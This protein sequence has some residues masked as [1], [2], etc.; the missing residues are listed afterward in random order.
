MIE[1][2]AYDW[3]QGLRGACY[4]GHRE[5]VDLMIEKGA[6]DWN[7]GLCCA[8]RYGHREIVDLM[9]EKGATYLNYL[10]CANKLH[11]TFSFS[12]KHKLHEDDISLFCNDLLNKLIYSRGCLPR[13]PNH[14]KHTLL[15]MLI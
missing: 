15:K 5:I 1:K 6:N 2:G 8:C 14:I 13:L 11:M 12:K 4:G 7:E 9:I 10:K 3:N